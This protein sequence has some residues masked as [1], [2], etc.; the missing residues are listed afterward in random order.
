MSR[1]NGIYV[2]WLAVLGAAILAGLYTA[3]RLFTEG[4]VLFNANDVVIWTLPLG[5]YVFFALT[6]SG[7]GLLAALP[8]VFGVKEYLPAAKRLVYLA[9]ATL[10]A[11]F[12]SIGLELGSVTHI[13]YIFLSPNL[14][15]PIQIMGAVYSAELV[16]LAV[17]FWRLQADDLESWV[18]KAAGMGSFIC[19]LFGPLVLGSVFGITEARP[20]FFG[21]FLPI[22]SLVIAVVSGL[23]AFLLYNQVYHLVSR[24]RA[25]EEEESLL[26]D[27]GKK[28][29]FMLFIALLFYVLWAVFKSATTLPDF[30]TDVN[31][32]LA[33]ILVIP[34]F[35]TIMPA[36][37]S[38]A[39]GKVGAAVFTLVIIF[40]LH[41]EV[42]LGGQIRP[43]GPK[44]EG[45][46]NVLTYSPNVWEWLV[47]VFSL[48]V[49]LLLSTMGEKLLKLEL[50][51]R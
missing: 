30:A 24:D 26:T 49:A 6:S 10:M 41:M 21:S 27:A 35:M 17:K 47:V 4:H 22:L 13:I 5:S 43:M 38:S 12:I 19:A 46:P 9:I 45:L 29:S 50:K 3:F 14:S 37:R 44:A 1:S 48:A 32:N 15:S 18:S 20:T 51:S 31:F 40:S 42:L 8:L 39:W 16:F 11:A 34:L 28:L 7:L 36:I 2:T 23:A 33:L 25:T